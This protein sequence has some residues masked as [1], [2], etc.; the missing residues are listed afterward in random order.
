MSG[1]ALMACSNRPPNDALALPMPPEAHNRPDVRVPE[2]EAAPR[3]DLR[4]CRV[5]GSDEREGGNGA[6]DR[7]EEGVTH[8]YVSR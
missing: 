2:A 3:L 6:T 8:V 7:S 5:R 1:N 4:R